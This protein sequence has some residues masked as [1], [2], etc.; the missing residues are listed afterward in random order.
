[1]NCENVIAWL[2]CLDGNRGPVDIRTKRLMRFDSVLRATIL[3]GKRESLLMALHDIEGR[4]LIELQSMTGLPAGAIRARVL[5]T[6]QR[7]G[8]LLRP[9]RPK[10]PVLTTEGD[11]S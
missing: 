8:Q 2:G 4:T 11:E 7:L 10:R 5:K 3:L 6:R 9:S 1:M